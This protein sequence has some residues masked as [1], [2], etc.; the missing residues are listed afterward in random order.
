MDQNRRS[1]ET[2]SDADLN[3]QHA[4]E[5]APAAALP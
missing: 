4:G 1:I 5:V 3:L 2:K